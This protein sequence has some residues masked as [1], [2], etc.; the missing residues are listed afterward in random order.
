MTP[1]STKILSYKFVHWACPQ[2]F[3]PV[4]LAFFHSAKNTCGN[5][6]ITD[7]VVSANDFAIN[8]TYI[9]FKKSLQYSD[10]TL[11]LHYAFITSK[12]YQT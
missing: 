9:A 4:Q 12:G 3:C 10:A 6:R 11:F 5:G 2:R 7:F 1:C 8:A